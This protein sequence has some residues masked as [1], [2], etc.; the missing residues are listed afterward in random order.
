M[1]D[2]INWYPVVERFTTKY[3]EVI[4]NLAKEIEV[5]QKYLAPVQLF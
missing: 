4:V 5:A 3:Y 2:T 1:F